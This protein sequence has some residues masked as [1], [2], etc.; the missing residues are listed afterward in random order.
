[1]LI[2]YFFVAAFSHIRQILL[3]DLAELDDWAPISD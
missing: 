3:G 2:F 1:M